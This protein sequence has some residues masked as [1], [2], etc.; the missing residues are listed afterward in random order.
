MCSF[1]YVTHKT[2]AEVEQEEKEN[3]L[4][5]YLWNK[6]HKNKKMSSP[7]I[8]TNKIENANNSKMRGH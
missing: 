6:F 3:S 2:Y 7:V 1:Y 5:H 8:V 4:F